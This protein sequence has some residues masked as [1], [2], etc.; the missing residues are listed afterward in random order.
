MGWRCPSGWV[1]AVVISVALG[2]SAAHE[3]GATARFIDRAHSHVRFAVT[4]W[5]FVEVEGRF[6]DFDGAIVWDPAHP[7]RAST[8]WRVRVASVTT[9][10]PDRDRAL[11][12]REYFDVAHHPELTFAST[13]VRA[14]A[15]DRLAVQGRITL[16]GVSRPLTLEIAILDTRDL[17]DLGRVTLFRTAFTLNRREFGIVGG[18][19]L[20]PVISDQVR[21]EIVVAA[22]ERSARG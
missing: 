10:E 17:P 19:L 6:L 5:G 21:I 13:E 1:A 18:S 12:A 3:Q 4:K 9:G 8:H 16:R 2:W 14:V 20:G 22:S 7:E 15:P 11:L